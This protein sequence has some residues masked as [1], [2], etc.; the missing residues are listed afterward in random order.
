MQK[1]TSLFKDI[2]RIPVVHNIHRSG[3]RLITLSFSTG[4]ICSGAG[5][6]TDACYKRRLQGEATGVC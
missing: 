2:G 5:A 6:G 3:T 1:Y 4:K